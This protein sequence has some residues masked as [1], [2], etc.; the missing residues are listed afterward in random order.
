MEG[1]VESDLRQNIGQILQRNGLDLCDLRFV[2]LSSKA[3][4]KIRDRRA[5]TALKIAEIAEKNRERQAETALFEDHAADEEHRTALNSGLARHTP[6]SKW[7]SMPRRTIWSNSSSRQIM[8]TRLG[9]GC[10]NAELDSLKTDV[11][12]KSVDRR[13]KHTQ[14]TQPQIH[15]IDDAQRQHQL[16]AAQETGSVLRKERVSEAEANAAAELALARQK[17]R[18]G[19]DARKEKIALDHEEE[20]QRLQREQEEKDREVKRRMEEK[21]QDARHEL[22]KNQSLLAADLQKTE[23]FKGMSEGQILALMAKNSPHVAA[24]IAKR[25]KAQAG[26]QTSKEVQD[27]YDKILKGKES[28]ADRLERVMGRAMKSMERVAGGS[29]SRERQQKEEIQSVMGQ[30][31]DRMADV[32][33]AKAAAPGTGRSQGAD[34]VCPKCHRQVSA[35]SQFCETCGHK[36]FE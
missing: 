28:E 23:I 29:V 13:I 35:G 26:G 8:R 15:A 17:I 18:L 10:E 12:E 14:S 1:G 6:R 22:E 27:L 19:M 11:Q 2:D 5:E 7:T 4:D 20:S 31:M 30:S 21:E 33:A 16:R 36:F 9:A 32:A 25:A 3:Y 24:A 34:I